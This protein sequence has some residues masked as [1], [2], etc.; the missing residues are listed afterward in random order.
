MIEK[1]AKAKKKH[2]WMAGFTITAPL[3]DEVDR[4]INTTR[5][6]R[7]HNIRSGKNPKVF[8]NY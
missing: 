8:K 5:M 3:Q 4:Y 2:N 7:I 6:D 1:M